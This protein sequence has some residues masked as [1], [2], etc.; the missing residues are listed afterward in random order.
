[1]RGV[2]TRLRC[3]K[4]WVVVMSHFE[5]ETFNFRSKI[6]KISDIK[7]GQVQARLKVNR[8]YSNL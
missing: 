4:Q 6:I 8:G 7:E 1:M 3:F 5:V 2:P